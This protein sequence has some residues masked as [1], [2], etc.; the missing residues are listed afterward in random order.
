MNGELRARLAAHARRNTRARLR[1]EAAARRARATH[2]RRETPQRVVTFILSTE[3]R[4]SKAFEGEAKRFDKYADD[5]EDE[6]G[7]QHQR[8][9]DLA[10]GAAADCAASNEHPVVK[11]GDARGGYH[12]LLLLLHILLQRRRRRRRTRGIARWATAIGESEV[13]SPVLVALEPALLAAARECAE[14][15]ASAPSRG[16][17]AEA[18]FEVLPEAARPNL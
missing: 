4:P 6:R 1:D 10:Q 12:L 18:V 15:H 11:G 2:R 3:E 13:E 9:E 14:R 7:D 17:A 5:K 8:N 16:T